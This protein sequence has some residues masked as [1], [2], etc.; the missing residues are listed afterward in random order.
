[1][2]NNCA[3]EQDLYPFLSAWL[4]MELKSS[5]LLEQAGQSY[6]VFVQDVSY[7]S[8]DPGGLW[9]RPDLA[10]VVYRRGRFVPNWQTELFS[11]EV[12]TTNGLNDMAVYEAFAHT[13]FAHYTYLF[14]PV[15]DDPADPK[16]VGLC[17]EFG[18]GILTARDPIDL[19]SYN[20]VLKAQRRDIDASL[21]DSFIAQRF[22]PDSQAAI[23]SWLHGQGWRREVTSEAM[24][25]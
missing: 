8:A 9:S 2:T 22:T 7:A 18:I 21:V 1:M 10:A 5:K 19:Q 11:F 13:R 20:M 17:K 12:K 23:E 24:P 4:L 14:W 3:R 15:G 16:I 25:R 6:Q